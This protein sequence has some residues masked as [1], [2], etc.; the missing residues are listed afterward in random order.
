MKCNTSYVAPKEL[1]SLRTRPLKGGRKSILLDYTKDGIRIRENLHLY[2]YPE[3]RAAW[4]ILN[5]QTLALAEAA[6]AKRVLEIQQGNSGVR[7]KKKDVLLTDY[8]QEVADRYRADGHVE[9]SNTLLKIRRWL[10]DF[11]KPAMLGKIDKGYV[12]RFVRHLQDSNLSPTTVRTYFDNLNTVFNRAYRDERINENPISRIDM[13][14][15][16]KKQETVREYLTLDEIR[17]LMG[18]RCAN[19]EVKRAFLFSCFTGLRLS[20]IESLLYDNI[21]KTQSGLQVEARMIKTKS[22]AYIPLASNAT[23]LLPSPVPSSGKVFSLPSRM[24]IGENIKNWMKDAGIRKYITFHCA[25]HTYAT[26]LLTYG[27]DIYTVCSLLGH[28]DVATT[29]IYAR[30]IDDKKRKAVDC[31]P[32]L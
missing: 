29:Q 11:G 8:V 18:A 5:E 16:P 19:P 13:N 7:V 22:I 12:L 10:L 31:I 3:D 30:V 17:L 4:R 32:M 24:Q 23:S 6:K 14:D 27:A 26:L 9:Y 25:R 1:V 2:L 20:D 21:R 15:K 28:R